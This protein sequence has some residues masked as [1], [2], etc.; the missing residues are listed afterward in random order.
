MAMWLRRR[1]SGIIS[2][3]SDLRGHFFYRLIWLGM[4]SAC[5]PIILAGTVY[6]QIAVKEAYQ[7]TEE[8]SRV[9]LKL[10]LDRI[11][12]LLAGIEL[13]SFHLALDPS[14]VDFLSEHRNSNDYLTN[15]QNLAALELKKNTNDFI[16][17][18]LLY[19]NGNTMLNSVYYG[20][21]PIANYP[22]KS[23]ID[24]VLSMESPEAQWLY[25]PQAEKSGYI[26]FIR[27]L[28]L[29]TMNKGMDRL[30]IHI[31][32]DMLKSHMND[33]F[34]YFPG[35]SLLV[36]DAK[37]R[38]LFHSQGKNRMDTD[39]LNDQNIKR[40]IEE[41]RPSNVF[42]AKD[43]DGL[44]KL[45]SYQKT[46]SGRIYISLIPKEEFSKQLG[47]IRWMTVCAVLILILVAVL[48]TIF[49]SMRVYSPIQQLLKHGKDLSHG[50]IQTNS[51]NEINYIKECLNYL[52]RE[53]K[54]LS[55][56]LRKMEPDLRERFF[57]KHLEKGYVD[58]G[59]LL[60]ECSDLGISVSGHYIVLVVELENIHKEK[61]FLPDDKAIIG[62]AITNVMGELLEEHN[63]LNGY[64]LNFNK[65]NGVAVVNCSDMS[66]LV[67]EAH[68]Y[69]AAVCN[70]LNRFLKFK[71]SIGMGSVCAHISDVSVS[72]R[73]ALAALEYRLIDDSSPVLYIED[74]ENAER[75]IPSFYPHQDVESIVSAL[76]NKD[77]GA[78][79]QALQS[80]SHAAFSIA[81]DYLSI[82]SS[83]FGFHYSVCGKSRRQHFSCI[84]E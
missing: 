48:L 45:Y 23:D 40:I 25:L 73:E 65:G 74:L 57:H 58:Q 39:G 47:W 46:T 4:I 28:P 43:P 51:P 33:S 16:G 22:F 84:G 62:F 5:I 2:G 20:Q 82:L 75:K 66:M 24:F 13:E 1:W 64:T 61:R 68:K 15:K 11:E 69:A 81:H 32:I 26:T 3:W 9:S 18:I 41:Q 36:T 56:Y 31:R 55:T 53:T 10:V 63:S 37:G 60:K 71:V 8:E 78:A 70:A 49:N 29:M 14:I 30:I 77:A 34:F 83:S 6:Y 79:K 38:T 44:E 76:R 54:S 52:N 12:S 59:L 67:E 21:I 27:K 17:E 35:K 19:Q 7:K 50:R 42:L 80:F 72:Y